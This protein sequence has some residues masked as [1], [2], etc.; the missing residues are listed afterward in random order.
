MNKNILIIGAGPLPNDTVGIREAAGL[1]T[2][3][4][5]KTIANEGHSITL[6][7]IHN[8]D[9]FTEQVKKDKTDQNSY[10]NTTILR[11][12]RHDKNLKKTIQNLLNKHNRQNKTDKTDNRIDN[13]IDNK[14]DIIFGINT[15][16]SFIA[17]QICP[18]NTPLWT[19]LNGWIM[20]E[21]QARGFFEKT[22]IHFANAWRQEKFILKR[23]DKISTVSTAQKFCTIGEMA[24]I[25]NITFQNF[26][27]INVYSLPNTTEF[28]KT[29]KQD[30]I[31]T[32]KR[33]QKLFKG[34]KTPKESI[35]ISH[36]GGYNNWVDTSTLFTAID[37]AMSTCPYLYF[38]ST[39]GAIKNV[40]N[41][42]FS[43]FLDKIDTS[44]HKE[45]YIFLGWIQ[46]EDMHKVYQESDIGINI[47]FSCIETQTGARNRLNEMLKFQLPII[48]T[49]ESEIA[50]NIGK[51]GAGECVPNENPNAVT[52]AILKMATM[53]I[54][55]N[56]SQYK[57]KCEFM[58]TQIYNS[59]IIMQPVLDFINTPI[60]RDKKNTQQNTPLL[61]VKNALWYLKKNGI[62]QSFNK[63]IQRFL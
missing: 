21:S 49:G 24:S 34:V 25:G 43:E 4:F 18:Q 3:Q 19:D 53:A 22:N 40:S 30:N 35:I 32:K 29:D 27:T 6:V 8:N 45:R 62:Q 10:K 52:T 14:I 20:A 17:A 11:L 33:T 48:T 50:E 46:T 37:N 2:H 47:D 26:H 13:K 28:F 7:C 44:K 59:K 42:A 56:L 5:T 60:I 36:I 39:G 58:H 12:H 41:K 23:A 31:D 57:K 15:F 54:E 61:F 55:S 1:R 51:Y 38:V 63:F 16:P 9:N